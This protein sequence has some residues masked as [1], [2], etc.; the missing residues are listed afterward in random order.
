MIFFLVLNRPDNTFNFEWMKKVSAHLDTV[1][2]SQGAAVLVTI[3]TGKIFSTGFDFKVWLEHP[4]NPY[5]TTSIMQEIYKKMLGLN[6]PTMCV[7]NGN[8]YAGGAF[9]ALCHDFRIMNEKSNFALTEIH[10]GM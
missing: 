4:T 3:G 7:L 6:V 5:H 8:A 2:N 1:A 10:H 9:F